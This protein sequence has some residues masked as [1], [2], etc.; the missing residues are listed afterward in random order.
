MLAPQPPENE[1]R[2]LAALSALEVLDTPAERAF[3]Q[4]T[5][6]AASVLGVP[7]ALVSLVDDSRQWFKSRYGLE[8]PETSR[9]VS[10]CGHVVE[11][12]AML[13]VPDAHADARFSD[14]PLV[15]GEPRVR[16]YAGAPLRTSQDFVLGTLCVIDH[17]P[18][19]PTPEQLEQLRLIAD[20]VVDQL[21]ARRQRLVAERDRRRMR[22][23]FEVMAEGIVVQEPGGAIIAANDAAAR[24]LGV[25]MDALLGRTSADPRWQATRDDGSPWPGDT[26]PAM[27][28][29][30]TGRAVENALMGVASPGSDRRWI[31]INSR[32][33]FEGAQVTQA[34]TTFTDVTGL[35]QLR[36]RERQV[37]R[38]EHLVTIGTLAAG[39]GHE[40]NN[41]LAFILS[42]LDY[43]MEELTSIGGGS[44]TGRVRELMG[45]LQEVREGADRIRRIVRSLRAFAREDTVTGPIELNHVI[46]SSINV[47]QHEL[48]RCARVSVAIHETPLALGDESR[49]GQILVNLLVNAAQAFTAP[50][51]ERN[52]IT[53]TTS[54]TGDL[55]RVTV[56]DNGPGIRGGDEQRIFDPFFTTKDPGKGT[57]LGL[58]ISRSLANGM[59]G[60]LHLLND[61]AP[62]ATFALEL[63]RAAAPSD[64][65][66]SDQPKTPTAGL[67]VLVVDDEVA[68]VSSIQR[69]LGRAHLVQGEHD[70]R[71]AI[72]RVEAG[73]PFDLVL[74][75]VAM[76]HVT[77]LEVRARLLHLQPELANRVVL[78]TGGSLDEELQAQ[79]RALADVALEKPF[80]AA[81][82]RS[83][84]ARFTSR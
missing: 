43:C 14:N 68:L 25:S 80:T 77:G 4:L 63:P 3:D 81:Q 31:N 71:R 28:V 11:T 61:G 69:I 79:L 36:E 53:V 50:A 57:G 74:C 35:V 40:I 64:A 70:P 10:F 33:V 55:V 12:S 37:S 22:V 78:M 45:V 56:S 83:V 51:P 72:A 5:T 20:Q 38:Q 15:T 17:Q 23:I 54:A 39:V 8:A 19:T 6:L 67:R 29:L 9:E 62:G 7:I 82:L 46:Q 32:P 48:K 76:P 66:P 27:Q 58:S 47:A 44:P 26:H 60:Q 41:P 1:A 2:R 52:L 84:V 65:P 21:E 49:V 18:R 30:H 13:V 24:V 42:N 73:E 34:V 75:D 16:F 59:G